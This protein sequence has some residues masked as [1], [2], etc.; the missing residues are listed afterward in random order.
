LRGKDRQA[1]ARALSKSARTFAWPR[2]STSSSETSA[3]SLSR[4]GGEPEEGAARRYVQKATYEV[5]GASMPERVGYREAMNE[6][7]SL[8]ET[9]DQELNRQAQAVMDELVKKASTKLDGLNF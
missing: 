8:T 6:G 2:I 3:P 9:S 4:T 5:L 7:A 1:S